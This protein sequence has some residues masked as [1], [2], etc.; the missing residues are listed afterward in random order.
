MTFMLSQQ[1]LVEAVSLAPWLAHRDIQWVIC[2]GYS[3]SQFRPM[4][5]AWARLLKTECERARVPFFMKQLGT[6]YAKAHGLRDWKGEDLTEFPVD[7]QVQTFPM[8]RE[9]G[10]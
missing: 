3:G 9:G 10:E 6:V 7:L 2:G 5:L 8:R 4:Q 1:P